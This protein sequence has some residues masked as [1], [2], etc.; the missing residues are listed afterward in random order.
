[1]P[2]NG[3]HHANRDRHHGDDRQGLDADFHAALEG[4]LDAYGLGAAAPE[5]HPEDALSEQG[6][7][8]THLGDGGHCLAANL[9]EAFGDPRR[10][11]PLARLGHG[12]YP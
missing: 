12:G 10:E 5:E 11:C 9:I 6:G 7:A 4:R 2:L 8:K 1:M 3:Q